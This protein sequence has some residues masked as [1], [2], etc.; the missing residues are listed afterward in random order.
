L[1]KLRTIIENKWKSWYMYINLFHAIQFHFCER[2]FAIRKNPLK[3]CYIY[4]LLLLFIHTVT[5]VY[6]SPRLHSKI[7]STKPFPSETLSTQSFYKGPYMG[8]H[9]NDFVLSVYW[10][11]FG[12][13]TKYFSKG[14]YLI[15][16]WK[17]MIQPKDILPA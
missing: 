16:N 6:K 10:Y 1:F 17:T 7:W 11:H 13:S 9:Q 8:H 5:F 14:F 12:R 15:R 2:W 4:L 3:K